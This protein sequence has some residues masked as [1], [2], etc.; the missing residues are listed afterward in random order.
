VFHKVKTCRAV[1][2]SVA[3]ETPCII[4]SWAS[5]GGHAKHLLPHRIFLKKT[6]KLKNEY[7]KYESRDSA[8]GIATGYGLDGRGIG[9]P[10]PGRGKISLFST[11]SRPVP[12]PTEASTQWVPGDISPGVKRPG[13]KADHS[14]PSSA[15]VKKGGARPSPPPHHMSSWYSA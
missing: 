11:S 8:V 1:Q 4:E 13:R 15:E 7:R 14:P 9:V 10:S 3:Q 2:P 5:G 6:S 12:G